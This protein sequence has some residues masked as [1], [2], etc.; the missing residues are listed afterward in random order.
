MLTTLILTA[1]QT[2]LPIMPPGV[3]P[4]PT[5]VYSP[6]FSE[7][8]TSLGSSM[9]KTAVS[10]PLVLPA[11]F[12][13]TNFTVNGETVSLAWQQGQPPFQVQMYDHGWRNIGAP[14]TNYSC[15]FRIEQ[16]SAMFRVASLS[17]SVL[18][19]SP[20]GNDSTGTRGDPGKPFRNLYNCQDVAAHTFYGAVTAAKGG[21][22]LVV[23]PGVSY[24]PAVPLNINSTGLNLYVYPGA[25]LV[26]TNK[27][28]SQSGVVQPGL[29]GD[30]TVS[31]L[32]IPGNGSQVIIDGS[33]TATNTAN[34]AILGWWDSRDMASYGYPN[35]VADNVY[36]SGSGKLQGCMDGIYC[37]QTNPSISSLYVTT[38][39]L[40]GL[41]DNIYVGGN[42][43]LT[44]KSLQ[45]VVG[46][47]T[48]IS[49]GVAIG[50]G[51]DWQDYGSSFTCGGGTTTY[52]IYVAPS[53]QVT[54]HSTKLILTTQNTI[55]TNNPSGSGSP[56]FFWSDPTTSFVD[57]DFWYTN[58]AGTTEHVIFTDDLAK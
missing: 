17:N 32:I 3:V 14:V 21:D 56:Y 36:F 2:A 12:S 50:G 27:W 35:R 22:T 55:S 33:V 25:A 6:K 39:S 47:A 51:A 20:N 54:F 58:Q 16:P 24:A 28:Y 37:N 23:L 29:K 42:C 18:W 8:K 41:Y 5:P 15:S 40:N 52:P 53:T 46:A 57:G 4:K 9:L 31:P 13:I 44:T 49:R 45:S 1:F 48:G 38:L 34:D 7:Q 11:G 10:V 43:N 26:R 19:V 30:S